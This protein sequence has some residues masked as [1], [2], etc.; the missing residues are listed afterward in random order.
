MQTP[1][2]APMNYFSSKHLSY[3]NKMR[4][5]S[6][7][8]QTALAKRIRRR[9]NFVIYNLISCGLTIIP[10]APVSTA[11]LDTAAATA[12]ATLE[13]KGLGIT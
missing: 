6:R 3:K 7:R 10:A 5:I 13:S 12:G 1:E 2:K 8:D 9:A 4:P 11:A